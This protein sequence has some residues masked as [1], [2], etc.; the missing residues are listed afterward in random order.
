MNLVLDG[1]VA[2]N[3]LLL[4][5]LFE[6]FLYIA[7]TTFQ[8]IS[9]AF[10]DL[11]LGLELLKRLLA[12]LVLRIFLLEVGS[13]LAEIVALQELAALGLLIECLALLELLF[14]RDLFAFESLDLLH[15]LILLL[16]GGFGL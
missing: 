13:V 10:E 8:D 16:F 9:G 3:S 12:L 15:L 11:N 7:S 14:E 4:L 6:E 1:G 5:E 2:G